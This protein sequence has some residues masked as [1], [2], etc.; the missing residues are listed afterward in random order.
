MEPT[1][2][3]LG[4]QEYNTSYM[5]SMYD[6]DDEDYEKDEEQF[7]AIL[8]ETRDDTC[9]KKYREGG[10]QHQGSRYALMRC[11]AWSQDEEGDAGSETRMNA[12]TSPTSVQEM[13]SDLCTISPSRHII[14]SSGHQTAVADVLWEQQVPADWDLQ[15]IIYKREKQ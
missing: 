3:I 2:E 13:V 9:I 10:Q 15:S 6:S 11:L 5:P 4:G 7:G 14:E 8:D 12:P 1:R